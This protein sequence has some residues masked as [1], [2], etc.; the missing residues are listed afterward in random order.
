MT[1]EIVTLDA[2][3][4]HFGVPAVRKDPSMQALQAAAT[5]AGLELWF[6]L[7]NGVAVSSQGM[8]ALAAALMRDHPDSNRFWAITGV[9]L[10]PDEIATLEVWL[11]LVV[12]DRGIQ[13]VQLHLGNAHKI[14]ARAARRECL[15]TLDDA[16]RD[17]GLDSPQYVP[18]LKALKTRLSGATYVKYVTAFRERLN[19][20]DPRK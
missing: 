18:A 7:T 9:D 1:L 17:V 6:N 3:N 16:I 20:G 8:G 4:Q 10:L 12:T 11:D 5:A 2:L 14:D 13:A 19:S 15:Q